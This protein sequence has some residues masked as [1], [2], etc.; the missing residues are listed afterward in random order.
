MGGLRAGESLVCKIFSPF[1]VKISWDEKAAGL[2]PLSPE[3]TLQPGESYSFPE[4]WM[5]FPLKDEVK[6]AEQAAALAGRVPP[7]PF[8]AE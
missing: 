8:Q 7:S 3:I 1:S 2:E 5:L 6:S 4:K